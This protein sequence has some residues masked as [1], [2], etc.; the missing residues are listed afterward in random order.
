MSQINSFS[1]LRKNAANFEKLQ[2]KLKDSKNGG[3]QERPKDNRFW[4]AQQ[5]S[6]GNA[7]AVIR[8]LPETKGDSVELPFVKIYSYG[9][10]NPATGKWFIEKSPKTLGLPCPIT[11]ANN[12]LWDSGSAEDVALA[13]SRKR[14]TK[15]ISNIYVIS[16]PA[17]PENEGKVFLFE[18]GPAI[19]DLLTAAMQPEFD[20]ETPI[21]VFDFWEGANFKLVITKKDGYAN[22][23][24]SKFEN[25]APLKKDDE[26]LE[27]IWLSQ[28]K[29][30]EFV[31]PSEFKS[32]DDLK[33]Q[34]LKFEQSGQT[35][36]NETLDEELKSEKEK[37]MK[38]VAE[39]VDLDLDSEDLNVLDDDLDDLESFKKLVEF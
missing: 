15:Y 8:F 3:K 33:K 35:K 28:F 30:S 14:K 31:D 32:Y 20:D 9:F 2:S 13:K 19:F 27:Q 11:E 10:K 34:L 12:V 26:E 38:A 18:Y 25:I 1:Q 16:D 22:Y 21:K 29:L 6:A 39:D 24:K 37:S 23:D 36:L 5:D 4:R 7:K 17:N